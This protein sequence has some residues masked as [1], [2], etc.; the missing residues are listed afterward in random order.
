MAVNPD[1]DTMKCIMEYVRKKLTQFKDVKG[2]LI[3]LKHIHML[4]HQS[5]S[6]YHGY[7]DDGW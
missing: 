1:A 4:Q 2:T 3:K 5:M 7:S 6:I